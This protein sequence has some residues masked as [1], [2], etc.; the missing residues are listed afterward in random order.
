[1][2]TSTSTP[3]I[4]NLA[5]RDMDPRTTLAQINHLTLMTVAARRPRQVSTRGAVQ[6]R[7]GTRPGTYLVIVLAAD[8]TYSLELGRQVLGGP[9]DGAW[10]S[11]QVK[12]G[13]YCDQLSEVVLSLFVAGEIG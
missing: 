9:R 6:V 13:I 2:T 10:T 7:I 3:S 5:Q 11:L 8:D 12:H 4:L 1:M